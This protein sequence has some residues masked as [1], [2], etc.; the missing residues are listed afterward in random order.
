MIRSQWSHR[1][2]LHPVGDD[3]RA[4][5]GVVMSSTGVEFTTAQPILFRDEALVTARYEW[6]TE[7]GL[8]FDLRYLERP[9]RAFGS[10]S[11]AQ[12]GA[13]ADEGFGGLNTRQIV[14]LEGCD[15]IG[16]ERFGGPAGSD[17]PELDGDEADPDERRWWAFDST[18][19]VDSDALRLSVR[20]RGE[21][22]VWVFVARPSR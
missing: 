22:A 16:V 10:E 5:G 14:L 6:V 1:R 3:E 4:A 7:D 9:V 15:A 2:A 18:Q 11:A 13:G 20:W 12:D 17:E 21:E 19:P 8:R